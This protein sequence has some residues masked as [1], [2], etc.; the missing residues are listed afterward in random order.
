MT[1]SIPLESEEID[2]MHYV[3]SL[4]ITKTKAQMKENLSSEDGIKANITLS[5]S[6]A[7]RTALREKLEQYKD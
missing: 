3:L 5:E 2:L 6:L 4:S 1:K 7:R